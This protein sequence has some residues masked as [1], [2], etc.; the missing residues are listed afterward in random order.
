[1]SKVAEVGK[2]SQ[3]VVLVV[4]G[5]QAYRGTSNATIQIRVCL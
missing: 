3:L 5:C 1:V 2:A 4:T